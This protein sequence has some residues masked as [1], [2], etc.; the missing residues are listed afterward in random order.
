MGLLSRRVFIRSRAGILHAPGCP[1]ISE[2]KTGG[3]RVYLDPTDMLWEGA[4]E[5]RLAACCEPYGN[6]ERVTFH[7]WEHDE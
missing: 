6:V 1:T 7:R 5:N 2:W 3:T 4:D